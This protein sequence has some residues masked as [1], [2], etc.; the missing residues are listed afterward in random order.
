MTEPMFSSEEFSFELPKATNLEIGAQA[1]DGL[2][3]D[4]AIG[5]D[6]ALEALRTAYP[7]LAGEN[8]YSL[9]VRRN[10]GQNLTLEAYNTQRN[11]Q[12][13]PT[14]YEAPQPE[15][16]PNNVTY[17]DFSNRQVMNQGAPLHIAQAAPQQPEDDFLDESLRYAQSEIQ[18]PTRIQPVQE[19]PA[20]WTPQPAYDDEQIAQAAD[21]RAN[22]QLRAMYG[23]PQPTPMPQEPAVEAAPATAED[24][25]QA[26]RATLA[27]IYAQ[28]EQQLQQNIP[29]YAQQE[30]AYVADLRSRQYGGYTDQ[31]EWELAA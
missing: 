12:P 14:Q 29:S 4:T 5:I 26:H 18:G 17:V 23:E 20:T 25:L 6:T 15:A 1:A 21:A 31:G 22:E 11:A 30:Q 27:E 3:N 9:D 13:Q 19:A 7:D 10:T 28:Q 24:H 8:V 16:S 2:F